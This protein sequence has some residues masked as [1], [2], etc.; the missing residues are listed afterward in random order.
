MIKALIN[1][2]SK[3]CCSSFEFALLTIRIETTS[4]PCHSAIRV[5]AAIMR[6]ARTNGT[7]VG[8]A[9]G[10]AAALGFDVLQFSLFGLS[11]TLA[12]AV[13]HGGTTHS[14]LTL[15]VT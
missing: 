6:G 12:H 5:G 10:D 2:Q 3:V 15:P 11:A 4:S 8:D 14:L 9:F 13:N 7:C 1:T